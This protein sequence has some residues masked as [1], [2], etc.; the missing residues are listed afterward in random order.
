MLIA[1]FCS[2]LIDTPGRQ[3]RYAR[4]ASLS[5]ALQLAVSVEQAEFQERRIESFYVKSEKGSSQ[6]KGGRKSQRKHMCVG[7]V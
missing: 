5:E 3:V 2:G 1:S 7:I 6:D 4:P